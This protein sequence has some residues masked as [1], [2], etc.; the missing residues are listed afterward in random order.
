MA[1][2]VEGVSGVYYEGLKEIKSSEASYDRTKQEDLW[3][4]TIGTVARDDRERMAFIL[5]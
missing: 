4:W 3:G 5:D 2:D 1:D